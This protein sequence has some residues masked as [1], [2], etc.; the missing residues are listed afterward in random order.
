MQM[1]TKVRLGS[2]A[3]VQVLYCPRAANTAAYNSRLLSRASSA[4]DATAS[5]SRIPPATNV[6]TAAT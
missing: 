2:C 3:I 6:S 5:L 1:C 4:T